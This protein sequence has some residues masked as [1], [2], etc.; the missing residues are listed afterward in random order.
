MK[1]TLLVLGG[2]HGLGR[3]IAELA[4]QRGHSV[5]VADIQR[6]QTPFAPDAL[7]LDC[8]VTQNEAVARAVDGVVARFGALT[9]AVNAFG[10][11]YDSRL[12]PVPTP[13]Q[14]VD[15]KTW[16]HL[17]NT[18]LKGTWLA[19]KHQIRAMQADGGTII[20]LTSAYARVAASGMSPYVAAKHAVAALTAAAAAEHDR[21]HLRINAVAPAIVRAPTVTR[22]MPAG[23]AAASP[24][25]VAETVLSLLGPAGR[26]VHGQ[27]IEVGAS[28]S[29]F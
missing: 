28:V 9:A 27:T 1:R 23:P 21:R 12:G 14:S 19:M 6:P 4:L 11:G 18:H 29:P 8:D 17:I 15:P 13:I 20:N 25:D 10:A 7:H 22:V 3:A 24:H 26:A 5:A 16:H 2:A